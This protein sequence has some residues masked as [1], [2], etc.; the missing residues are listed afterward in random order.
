M[1][2]SPPASEHISRAGHIVYTKDLYTFAAMARRCQRLPNRDSVLYLATVYH[3]IPCENVRSN[4]LPRFRT[5]PRFEVAADCADVSFQT[6]S[7]I[8]ADSISDILHLQLLI[9]LLQIQENFST[10]SL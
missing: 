3:Q 1:T 9:A 4:N 7:W 5:F 2:A 8:Q 10:T 6:Y